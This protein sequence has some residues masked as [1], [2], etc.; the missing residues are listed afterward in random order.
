MTNQIIKEILIKE[1]LNKNLVFPFVNGLT[2]RER[3][4]LNLRE[5]EKT[6]QF[7]GDKFKITRQ[8]VQK[9]EE[10]ANAK[11]EYSKIIVDTLAEK[12]GKVVFTENEI[13]Q[14]FQKMGN[15]KMRWE[16]FNKLLWEN[17]R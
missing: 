2:Q 1:L 11:V 9:I 10:R 13:G 8:M 7:I 17:K 15:K 3:A 16:D 14:I 6:L 5:Q 12:I 4:V